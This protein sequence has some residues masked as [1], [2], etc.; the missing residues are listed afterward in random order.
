MV[1]VISLSTTTRG[2]DKPMVREKCLVK[3]RL[4]CITSVH[5]PVLAHQQR[6]YVPEKICLVNA[7][8]LQW[9][10]RSGCS[11]S[12]FSLIFNR[13]NTVIHINRELMIHLDI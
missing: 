9:L 10:V 6:E 8:F 1:I 3:T 13:E 4:T 7:F 2:E 11:L 12:L 5:A